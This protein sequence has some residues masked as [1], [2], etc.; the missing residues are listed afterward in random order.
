MQKL[1]FST[2]LDASN[3]A[4]LYKMY[5][6]IVRI[7]DVNFGRVMTKFYDLNYM[8]WRVASTAQAHFQ[9]VDNIVTKMMFNGTIVLCWDLIT[10]PQTLAT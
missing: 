8:K 4:G 1:P 7:F 6:I 9:S 2:M 5:P 10:L 3:D